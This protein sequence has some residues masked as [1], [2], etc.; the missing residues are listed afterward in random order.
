M[1]SPDD[2]N[3]APSS[4]LP[5]DMATLILA[6]PSIS[7]TQPASAALPNT[8]ANP[9]AEVPFVFGRRIAQ[10]GM[11][12]IL[13]ASD[14]KLGRTIAVKVMLSEAGCSE[15]QKQR[16]I[17]EAAVLG[18]LEHPNIVPIHDLGRDSEGQLFYTMKLVKGRTLQ[19]ILDDL[20]HEKK[21]ALDHYTLDRLLTIFRKVC[22]AL[23][24]AHAQKIIH[25]DLKPE[26][27][28][29]G[30][31][32]EVLV[33]DWGIAKILGQS[34]HETV[35]QGNAAA[36]PVSLSPSLPVT[37]SS[38]S[39]TATMDGAVMGT[40]NYMSPEQ[41]MGKVNEMDARSDIFS[42]GGILYAILTLR[43][44]VEGK[45]V[46]EVL[47]KVSSAS[48]TV[49]TTFG[50]TTGKGKAHAKGNVLEAS[51]IKPLPHLPGGQVPNALSAV[52]MKALT[53]DKAKRYQSIAAFS[54]DIEKYQGGFATSA[55]NAG[56]LTQVKLLIKRNKGI[57]TTAAAAWLLITALG[58][59]FVFNLRVKEQR[60]LAGEASA[61]AAEAEAV[62]KGEAARQSSMKANLAL[63]EAA[64]REGNGPEM[65]AALGEVPED[66][67][68]STW[69]YLLDQ[70]DS[71]FARIRNAVYITSVAA[72]PRRPG[73]FATAENGGKVT[74]LDVRTGASLLEFKPVF[75]P[76]SDGQ[77]KLA[78]SPDGERIAVGNQN[79]E[80][81][82]MIH[83]A[84][85]GK[86]L[87]EWQAPITY[88]LEF[89]PDGK[90]L[91]QVERN[92]KLVTVWD[93]ATGQPRWKHEQ[94]GKQV[95]GTFTPDSQHV[96]TYGT[97]ANVLLTNA[98][99]GKV[100]RPIGNVVSSNIAIRPDGKMIVASNGGGIKGV[101]LQDGKIAFDFRAHNSNIER[102][103][104]T[105][106]GARFVSVAL[107]PDGRQAIQ[108][109]DANSGAPLQSLLGGSGSFGDAGLHPLSGE[110]LVVGTSSRAWDLTGTPEKWTLSGGT[111][112][113][114][115]FWGSD[116]MVFAA[117][118]GQNAALQKL[119]AG[120][121]KLIWQPASKGYRMP[122]VSA[123]GRFAAIGYIGGSIEAKD[124]EVLLLRNTGA[125][126][127]QTAALKLSTYS[128]L[129]LLR[130]SPTGDR[131][132]KIDAGSTGAALHDP[133]TGQQT[134]QL[135]RKD[136]KKFWDLGWVGGGRQL[137]GLVTTKAERGNPGSE[138]WIV[139]WDAATGK[140][141][142]T[143]TNR[144]AM[145]VLAIAPDGHRFAEAG[146]DKTVR[147]RDATTLAVQQEFRAH[148]GPITALAWH[149]SK[150][151][152]AS[153]S[154]DLSLKIWD[155]ETGRQ[156][157]EF[158]GMVTAP[159]E[160][161]FSPSGQRLG[162][163]GNG[164]PTRIWEP[165][166]L[167][168]QPAAEKLADGW[169]DLLAP[170]SRAAILQTGN[171]WRL[172]NGALFSP[173][174]SFATL[175][176]PGILSGTSYQVRVKLRQLASKD[177]F[178][179][180]LPVADRM[181]GF[182]LDGFPQDGFYTSLLRVKGNAGR[183]LPGAVHGKQVLDSEQ[184]DLEVTVRLDGANATITT[185][186]DDQPLYEWTGPT[187]DLSPEAVHW[188]TPPG[189][190]ALGSVTSNWVVYEVKV[191]RLRK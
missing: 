91:L 141:V 152:I 119:Q 75:P 180:E 20:R 113:S 5:D 18:R 173:G 183:S 96:V 179:L 50:A 168:D 14:C 21:E 187:A 145:D 89:S 133:A 81:R 142:Q 60:A 114:I 59:W 4:E 71:S 103:I 58:V 182:D 70:S 112:S 87:L 108:L 54:A 99:D 186:L 28:M 49:P 165:R 57:F 147:I 177:Y 135:E 104:F 7:S 72:D 100:I 35:T 42:L 132:A 102:L 151:I 170:L 32:G 98:Q 13:E 51:K 171:G 115:A 56:A 43:P 164:N 154:A 157:E 134:V 34:D 27:I 44:P 61:I 140:I 156:L 158:R 88:R 105:P 123:D 169:E 55:E 16:F 148:D 124:K 2:L 162:C 47:Q 25:R 66:L 39:P 153:T 128:T 160:L 120:T 109:W 125:Q 78:F 9:D 31:F 131:L 118:P 117:A 93:A 166:S 149:P 122:S 121:P 10:G 77:I 191:K 144:T 33:M 155:F 68:D 92:S 159:T 3:P 86:K 63:A 172:E 163:A 29:V 69:H 150:P 129:T 79:G 188:K 40:P 6:K 37:L 116:D 167:N 176:L 106:D 41:A 26:N 94:E 146:A 11:G 65:Q 22:D 85:D 23:A 161:A 189:N 15:E 138:E 84:R 181:V 90:Q 97:R 111:T 19:Q 80:G 190:L 110:L 38:P 62:A 67:R 139:L 48:I 24:F 107:L 64:R 143:A 184:H 101:F 82:I 36:V 76:K 175:S 127:E 83:S 12:A 45:D 8:S 30:E 126:T 46:W 178:H 185:K 174:K 130:L 17:Q 52:A 1:A 73:V 74:L 95:L 53:L 137:V 136:I